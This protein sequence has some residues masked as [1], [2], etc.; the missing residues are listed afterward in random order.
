LVVGNTTLSRP[1]SLRSPHAKEA[2]GLS[3]KPLFPLATAVLQKTYRLAGGKIPL[4]GVGGVSDART[5]YAKIRAGASLVQLYSALVYQGPDLAAR[6]ARQLPALLK[7]DGYAHVSQAVG[8][9]CR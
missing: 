3:G 5:A 1:E 6:I 9:D 7:A 8:A 2:G 4:I